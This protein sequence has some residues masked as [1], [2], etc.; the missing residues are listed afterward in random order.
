MQI[1]DESEGKH[2]TLNILRMFCLPY[3]SARNCWL[4]SV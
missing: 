2:E 3:L 1:T 4:V